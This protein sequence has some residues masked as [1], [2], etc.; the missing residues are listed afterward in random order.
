VLQ[1]AIPLWEQAQKRA[2]DGLGA[3]RW[4]GLL[5]SLSAAAELSKL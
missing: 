4:R 2:V 3:L 1:K 5:N